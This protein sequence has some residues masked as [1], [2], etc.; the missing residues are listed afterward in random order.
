MISADEKPN[1]EMPKK[2]QAFLGSMQLSKLDHAIKQWYKSC[3]P[4]TLLRFCISRKA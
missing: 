2:N 4:M 1:Y 3:G